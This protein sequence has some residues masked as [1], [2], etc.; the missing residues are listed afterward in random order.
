MRG[1]KGGSYTV[2]T[3]KW[4]IRNTQTNGHPERKWD[5]ILTESFKWAKQIWNPPYT[6]L[7][8]GNL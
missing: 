8:T 6:I 5:F 3:A 7:S 4:S 2:N 1:R